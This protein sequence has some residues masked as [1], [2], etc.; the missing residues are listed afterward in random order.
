MKFK[1]R[2]KTITHPGI[3]AKTAVNTGETFPVAATIAEPKLDKTATQARVCAKPKFNAPQRLSRAIL[4]CIRRASSSLLS[5]MAGFCS[6][7][8]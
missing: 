6:T 2:A 4:A 1:L 3:A 8:M 5:G 7:L